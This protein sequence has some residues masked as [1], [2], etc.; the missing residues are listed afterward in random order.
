MWDRCPATCRWHHPIFG[1]GA[2]PNPPQWRIG[3]SRALLL[4][5][6][7]EQHSRKTKMSPQNPTFADLGAPKPIVDHLADRGITEPFPIQMAVLADALSGRDILGRAP[8]GSGKTLAF[9]IPLVTRMDKGQRRR[10]TALIL[11]P[12]RELAEQIGDEL[13]P[14]AQGMGHG[15]AVVYGGVGYKHQHRA[16]DRGASLVVACPGR[17][18][19]LLQMN[20]LTLE[21][22]TC[23]VID[24]ADRMADMGFLPAV[25]RILDA[26]CSERHVQLFS[27]T[28]DGPVAKLTRDFQNDPVRHEIGSSEPDMT[29]AHHIFWTVDRTERVPHVAQFIDTAGSTIVFTRTRHGAD[30][31]AKQL[32][33]HGID[34]A[35]I[36]GGRSQGQRNRALDAFATGKVGALVA[37]DVAARGIHV[38]DVGAV[39]HFDPPED[40]STYV[41]RSGR[42][43][44][45]G[46]SGVVLS[47][48]EPSARK[49]TTAMQ[50]KLGLPSG[51]TQPDIEAVRALDLSSTKAPARA[52]APK[53]SEG[54]SSNGRAD[55]PRA[56]RSRTDSAR[57]DRGREGNP[58]VQESRTAG[59]RTHNGG[60]SNGQSSNGGEAAGSEL[61]GRV[62]NYSRR[63]GFG[64]I[65][66]KGREDVFVHISGVD[67]E[68]TEVLAKGNQVA[69]ELSSGRKGPVAV[70]VR[71]LAA[72]NA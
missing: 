9:G 32:E 15:V 19:D 69:F 51:I 31:L 13:R 1:L 68:P 62:T 20:A 36:H 59:S 43:A 54:S 63:K 10:P 12:T 24:E 23:V 57:S 17:L 27:A 41:H 45:A 58:K 28:L 72:A 71:S 30:R 48:I 5:V 64:F 56:D 37:T 38:D 21:D 50:R 6:V 29:L 4:E 60:S 49:S 53:R 47:L 26:T 25:R 8:T 11:S 55:K 2:P 66:V 35:P 7:V 14:L 65:K 22:V 34:A 33:R 70:N 18:E 42:T 44:R 46:A 16:L 61:T 39:I 52:A 3:Q 67:G 40:A